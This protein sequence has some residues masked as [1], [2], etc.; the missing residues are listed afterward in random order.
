M[1][2]IFS[3]AVLA[4]LLT[5]GCS[6]GDRLQ[7]SGGE[8]EVIT[9]E[10]TIPWNVAS[11]SKVW[12]IAERGGQIVSIDKKTK[13]KTSFTPL[14]L[15]TLHDNGEGGF[16]GFELH[17]DFPTVPKAFAYYTYKNQEHIYNRLSELKLK[18]GKWEETKPLIDGIPAGA[19]H[20][21]GRIKFGPDG[22]LYAAAGDAGVPE[23]AQDG[24]SL[25]GKILRIE[26]DGSIPEDNPIADS[27][28]Y[29]LGHRNPQGL[30]WDAEGRMFASEHGQNHN[31]E[32][33]EILPGGNYGWPIIEGTESKKGFIPPL[34]HS[35]A[36]T[37]APSGMIEDDGILYVACLRG[38]KILKISIAEKDAVTFSEGNGRIRDI[39]M[40]EEKIYAITNNTDG[41]GVPKKGDDRMIL[42]R[43]S[44]K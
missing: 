8:K 32:I 9:K 34:I 37:W 26:A 22:M 27:A 29:S 30:T 21:G 4:L 5:S 12:W 13:R 39:L 25:S 3:A 19:I 24:S 14:L 7:T 31:D 41:R 36:E 38:E 43:S 40:E 1:K 17:P 42:I 23:T 15:K 6:S 16:L 2:K 33:N 18:G 10:L 20:N 44:L 35:G 11:D 28:I